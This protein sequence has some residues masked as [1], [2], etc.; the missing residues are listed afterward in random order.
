MLFDDTSKAL[1]VNSARCFSLYAISI[2]LPPK[3]YEG[4]TNT[5]YPISFAIEVASFKFFAKPF[6]GC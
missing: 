6:L 3:T 1:L 5:G 4:L 2:A